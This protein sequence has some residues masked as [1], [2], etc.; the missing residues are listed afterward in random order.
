MASPPSTPA[1]KGRKAGA[2][3]EDINAELMV[4][5]IAAN[6]AI[7]YNYKLM[8]A[9]SGTTTVFAI[10]HRFRKI[11]AKAKDL[12]EKVGDVEGLEPVKSTP[13]RKKSAMNEEDGAS[14]PE[15]TKRSKDA[16]KTTHGASGGNGESSIKKG[17]SKK[18]TA[19]AIKREKP[20]MKS[21][22]YVEDEEDSDQ[23]QETTDQN[24]AEGLDDFIEM[25]YV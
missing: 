12:L 11:K 17:R 13:K 6:P 24:A 23:D 5:L 14:S 9:L 18:G 15:T 1:S 8:S 2:S 19:K 25:D 16:V 20:S 10:E 21:P 22:A 7:N 3:D 4:L